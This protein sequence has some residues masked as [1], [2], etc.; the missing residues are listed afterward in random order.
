MKYCK[1][2]EK[3]FCVSKRRYMPRYIIDKKIKQTFC[4][5]TPDADTTS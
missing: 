5:L 1:Q 2:L 3:L 4:N